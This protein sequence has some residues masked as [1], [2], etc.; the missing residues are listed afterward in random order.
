MSKTKKVGSSGRFGA[1]YG[2]TLRSRIAEI[3]KR[4]RTKFKCPYCSYIKV[5]RTSTGIYECKKCNVK[6][7]G[8]AYFIE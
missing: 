6:F 1:R 5:K 7:T 3:E 4:Q 2:R 8:A